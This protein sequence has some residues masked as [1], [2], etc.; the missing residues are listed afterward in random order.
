V[1]I[2]KLLSHGRRDFIVLKRR[3]G[4]SGNRNLQIPRT[5]TAWRGAVK[6]ETGSDSITSAHT[7]LSNFVKDRP[8]R[9]AQFS[10]LKIHVFWTSVIRCD[11]DRLE[12]LSN[13]N[14]GRGKVFV[15]SASIRISF[16]TWMSLRIT[17]WSGVWLY[18]LALGNTLPWCCT[19]QLDPTATQPSS[20]HSAFPPTEADSFPVYRAP[21]LTTSSSSPLYTL[22]PDQIDSST[23]WVEMC[24][25]LV[26]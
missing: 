17:R 21:R 25:R 18:T 19:V 9:P 26:A 23:T 2:K 1:G 16:I 15:P 6:I 12:I 7:Q 4:P 14:Y 3:Q 22:Q 10:Q 20:H 8:S 5:R 24:I 11:L 13:L